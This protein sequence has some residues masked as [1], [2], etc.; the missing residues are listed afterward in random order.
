VIAAHM[1]R[2]LAKALKRTPLVT[3]PDGLTVAEFAVLRLLEGR[4]GSTSQ[5]RD[6]QAH[7]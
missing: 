6:G 7:V 2:G 1:K 4:N 3:K 5:K